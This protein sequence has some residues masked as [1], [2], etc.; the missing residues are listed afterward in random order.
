MRTNKL[1]YVMESMV[2]GQKKQAVELML[3]GCKSRPGKLIKQFHTL[4][5]TSDSNEDMKDVRH[6]LL[7]TAEELEK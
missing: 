5:I 6:L 4:L 1:A 2:N 3:R 7:L